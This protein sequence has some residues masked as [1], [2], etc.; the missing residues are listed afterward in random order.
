MAY[1]LEHFKVSVSE[2]YVTISLS[3][4][5]NSA[6]FFLIHKIT[7]YIPDIDYLPVLNI[8]N[9]CSHLPVVC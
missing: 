1:T 5:E 4:Y 6:F 3:I 7:S 9:T 2:D 8:T